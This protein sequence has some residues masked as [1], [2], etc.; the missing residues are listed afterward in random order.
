M[1]ILDLEVGAEITIEIKV[2]TEKLEFKSQILDQVKGAA[3]IEPIRIKGKFLSLNAAGVMISIIYSEEN[4]AP[5]MWRPVTLPAVV[6]KDQNC[7]K[8]TMKANGISVNRRDSYRLFV[9]VEATAQIGTNRK[10]IETLVKDI[11]ESGFSFVTDAKVETQ[12]G[13]PVHIVF[14]IEK[15]HFNLQG[16]LVRLEENEANKLIYGCKLILPNS[17]ISKYIAEKQREKLAADI[18]RRKE[19]EMDIIDKLGEAFDKK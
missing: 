6:Y 15:Y 18:R 19:L 3:I 4:Q 12:I 17:N 8:C 5:I 2:K 14:D 1:R 10:G 11:S 16:R 7:Y 9:G 13:V